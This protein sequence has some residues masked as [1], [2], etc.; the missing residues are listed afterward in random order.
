MKGFKLWQSGSQFT[1]WW[2]HVREKRITYSL[3]FS[4]PSTEAF[5]SLE[6]APTD[7]LSLYCFSVYFGSYES[8][9]QFSETETWQ[10]SVCRTNLST[11]F[12]YSLKISVISSKW[13]DLKCPRKTSSRIR[14][15]YISRI[16][17]KKW[18][19]FLDFHEQKW[20]TQVTTHVSEFLPQF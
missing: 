18:V 14:S 6:N 17:I 3:V 10:R 9:Q 11:V 12:Y 13:P 15:T 4:R 20:T 7:E 16:R 5:A 1:F 8:L 2:L 19:Y